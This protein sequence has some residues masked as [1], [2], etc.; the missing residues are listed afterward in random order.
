MTSRAFAD[1]RLNLSTGFQKAKDFLVAEYSAASPVT[2]INGMPFALPPDSRPVRNA[3]NYL[4]QNPLVK[5]CEVCEESFVD[6]EFSH[7]FNIFGQDC[8]PLCLWLSIEPNCLASIAT[9]EDMH[10]EAQ[11]ATVDDD[12]DP[13]SMGSLDEVLVNGAE[14]VLK[15]HLGAGVVASD[16]LETA[17]RHPKKS[18]FMRLGLDPRGTFCQVR[19]ISA[20]VRPDNSSTQISLLCKQLVESN[21]SHSHFQSLD[22]IRP[23]GLGIHIDVLSEREAWFFYRPKRETEIIQ[24]VFQGSQLRVQFIN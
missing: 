5:A 1:A 6:T 21:T 10:I 7:Q 3:K 24:A 8:C 9:L 11:L 16:A 14:R 18:W 13:D 23:L 12:L 19:S 4:R 17:F 2:Q 15:D 22:A 20:R